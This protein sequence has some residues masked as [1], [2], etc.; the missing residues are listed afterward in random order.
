MS[1]TVRTYLVVYFSKEIVCTK[2]RAHFIYL[3]YFLLPLSLSLSSHSL[4]FSFWERNPS[5]Q[6]KGIFLLLPL[7]GRIIAICFER[8]FWECVFLLVLAHTHSFEEKT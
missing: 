8:D 7:G 3:F 1:L 2:A 5:S 6:I 4:F